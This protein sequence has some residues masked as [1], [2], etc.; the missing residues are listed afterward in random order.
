MKAK[1]LLVVLSANWALT[2]CAWG[3]DQPDA[4]TG[5][6]LPASPASPRELGLRFH[7]LNLF[8]QY[9]VTHAYLQ[10][11]NISQ[12]YP[13]AP[14]DDVQFVTMQRDS[15]KTE[16]AYIYYPR[17]NRADRRERPLRMMI[18]GVKKRNTFYEFMEFDAFCHDRIAGGAITLGIRDAR[19]ESIGQYVASSEQTLS[20]YPNSK[21]D[22]MRSVVRNG[23]TWTELHTV[24]PGLP[25]IEESEAWM[26]PVG[27]SP[28]YFYLTFGYSIAARANNTPE[29]QQARRLFEQI[30]DS[31]RIERL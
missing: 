5:K 17:G 1:V 22:A 25:L 9:R 14:D 8:E 19:R 29:Y 27:N 31:F 10:G 18:E 4:R 23:N 7:T 15:G 21:Q 2:G 24:V 28:Y 16:P 13:G 30:L 11:I 20:R 3:P 12:C 6:P 26:L